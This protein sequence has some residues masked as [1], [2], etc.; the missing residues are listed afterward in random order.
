CSKPFASYRV[1]V[2]HLTKSEGE[3]RHGRSRFLSRQW[4]RAITHGGGMRKMPHFQNMFHANGGGLRP[5]RPG[6]GGDKRGG[7]PCQSGVGRSRS[8]RKQTLN[9]CHDRPV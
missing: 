8:R 7:H 2:S 3:E 6:F 4:L 9:S 5:G 1:T